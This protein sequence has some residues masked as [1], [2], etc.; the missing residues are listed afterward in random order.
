[1]GIRQLDPQED[2]VNYYE[3]SVGRG[4]KTQADLESYLAC[5]EEIRPV[6][7]H[8]EQPA[9]PWGAVKEIVLA[10]LFALA[11]GHYIYVD[12]ALE[13]ASMQHTIYFTPGS[14]STD[15]HLSRG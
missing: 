8:L 4:L 12:V 7:V 14:A 2:L 15:A 3:R 1:M 10:A 9:R 11:L 13:I 6:S 5:A